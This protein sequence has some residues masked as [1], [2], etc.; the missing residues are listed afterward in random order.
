MSPSDRVAIISYDEKPG[1]QAIA[2][3]SP[4]LPPKPGSWARG[5][6]G[7]SCDSPRRL[8]A[9]SIPGRIARSLD[10]DQSRTKTARRLSRSFIGVAHLLLAA[11]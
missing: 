11:R 2:T 9:V 1:I 3:T 7:H 5:H 8:T 6:C 10:L 4:D